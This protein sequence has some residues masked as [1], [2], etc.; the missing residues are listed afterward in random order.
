MKDE[1]LTHID[2]PG[3]LEKLYRSN[4]TGFKKA[5]AA[6]YDEIADRKTA[7]IWHERLNYESNELSWGRAGELTFVV[8]ASILAGVIAKL[9]TLLNIDSGSFSQRNWSFVVFPLLAA[10]FV[11]RQKLESKKRYHSTGPH[12]FAFFPLGS[13]RFFV[14]WQ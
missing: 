6:I 1:I 8:I 14:C 11:W 5:F 4:K 12:S 9:P 10:Y 2:H 3:Q 13:P 7:E